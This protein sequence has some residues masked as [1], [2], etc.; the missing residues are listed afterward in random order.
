MHHPLTSANNECPS[1]ETPPPMTTIPGFK[2]L[3]NDAT[4]CPNLL[5][6]SRTNPAAA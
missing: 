5:P 6:P 2:K 3:T 1:P 4:T